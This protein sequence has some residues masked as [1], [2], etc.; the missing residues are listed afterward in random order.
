MIETFIKDARNFQKHGQHVLAVESLK[1]AQRL[2][3]RCRF[4]I[5]IEKLISFNYRKMKEYSLAL[6]YINDAINF[7][8][9]KMNKKN[10]DEWAVCLMNK[11]VI[12]EE[13][14]EYE[15]AIDCYL[16]AVKTFINLFDSTPENFGIIING[17]LTV[18]LL[19]YNQKQYS[20][21]KEFFE[22]A[23][24]YFEEGKERD[25]RYLKLIELLEEIKRRE[26]P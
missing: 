6:F 17:L 10:T 8:Q 1:E 14:G 5:E 15:K 11:G 16:P 3:D 18:G 7:A 12:Y 23:L 4:K 25:I 13:M 22:K 19:Y 26:F 9:S 24:P 21:A 20:K 2:D